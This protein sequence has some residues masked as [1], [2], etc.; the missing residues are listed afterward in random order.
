MTSKQIESLREWHEE[1]INQYGLNVGTYLLIGLNTLNS[2]LDIKLKSKGF[3]KIYLNGELLS[4][5][6]EG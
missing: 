6:T 5:L 4:D 3:Y 1:I 2:V